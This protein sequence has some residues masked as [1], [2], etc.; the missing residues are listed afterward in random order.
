MTSVGFQAELW[1]N[2]R[3]F[4][5]LNLARNERKLAADMNFNVCFAGT[6]SLSLLSTQSDDLAAS[7]NIRN[8]ITV[9]NNLPD[10]YRGVCNIYTTT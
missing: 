4:D 6:S 7:G 1:G 5:C 2:V 9:V 8:L 3:T 10:D